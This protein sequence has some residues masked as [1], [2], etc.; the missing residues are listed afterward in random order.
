MPILTEMRC[1]NCNREQVVIKM[2]VKGEELSLHSCSPCDLRWWEADNGIVS[3]AGVL[4]L[5]AT[6]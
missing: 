3:L 4:D 2:T 1:P 6:R 5:A